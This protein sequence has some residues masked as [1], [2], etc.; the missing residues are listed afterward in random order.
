MRMSTRGRFGLRALLHLSGSGEGA[1]VSISMLA[2]VMD[3]SADYLM[4]LFVKLRRAGL[5]KSVRGPRGGFKLSRPPGQ[6][7]VGDI[8][9]AVEGPLAVTPCMSPTNC[10]DGRRGRKTA[11]DDCPK[12]EKCMA[13]IVWEKLTGE[14]TDLLERTDLQEIVTEARRRGIR[15]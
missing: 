14:I 4:Q 7:N 3:V 11:N 1:P 12:F 2:E 9:R 5:V 8:I 6:I 15:D 13:K 10:Y